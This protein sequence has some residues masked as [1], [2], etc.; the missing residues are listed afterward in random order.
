M[1]RA[2]LYAVALAVVF[3]VGVLVTR[4]TVTSGVGGYDG[5]EQALAEQ[6]LD[7][8]YIATGNPLLANAIVARRVVAVEAEAPGECTEP[9]FEANG[10]Y[11]GHRATV[12]AYTL[13]RVPVARVNVTC[14]GAIWGVT[15]GLGA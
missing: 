7:V 1:T 3:V 2:A 12:R 15:M 8:S 13:F 11:P 5:R 4:L 9:G 14:G 6:A 10:A